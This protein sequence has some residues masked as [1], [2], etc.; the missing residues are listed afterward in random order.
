MSMSTAK[1]RSAKVQSRKA[2][3]LETSK[4]DREKLGGEKLSAREQILQTA[5]RLFYHQGFRAV[6]ID[7]II[8][9]SGVAKMTLYKHFPSKDDLIVAYL[10]R[11]NEAFWEWCDAETKPFEGDPKRQLEV[12]FEGVAKLASSPQCFGCTFTGAAGEFPELEHPGHKAALEHKKQVL[13][14]FK[15]L[16][17]AAHLRQPQVVS[18]QLLM[19][20]DGAWNAARMF[21]PNS[22]AKQVADAA[23]LIIAA[24]S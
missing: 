15:E 2:R 22:H 11:S 6:G 13:A 12:I 3:D 18:E 5:T 17:K 9:E 8:A 21:G 7:T 1:V 20:M 19:L 23:K 14:K 10:N 24:H 16:T 4:P